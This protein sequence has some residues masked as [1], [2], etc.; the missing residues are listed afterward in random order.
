MSPPHVGDRVRYASP[1]ARSRDTVFCDPYSLRS[2][3]AQADRLHT[4]RRWVRGLYFELETHTGQVL[5]GLGALIAWSMLP[6][7]HSRPSGRA[8]ARQKA[9]PVPAVLHADGCLRA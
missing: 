6:R 8:L 7:Y 5:G 3:R 1:N 2:Y 4:I 9:M